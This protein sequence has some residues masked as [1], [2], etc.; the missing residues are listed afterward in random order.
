MAEEQPIVVAPRHRAMAMYLIAAP[1]LL[2]SS[3]FGTAWGVLMGEFGVAAVSATVFGEIAVG[4]VSGLRREK[5][6]PPQP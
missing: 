1:I 3:A 2:P 5:I 4:L 6:D